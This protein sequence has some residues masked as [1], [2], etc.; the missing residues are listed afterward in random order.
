MSINADPDVAPSTGDGRTPLVLR[1]DRDGIIRLTMNLG[2]RFNPLSRPMI[3][4][5]QAHL[6]RIAADPGARVVVIA[7]SGRGFSAGHDLAEMSA[8]TQDRSWQQALFAECNTLMETLP[9]LPQPVIAQVHGIATA[10]GCQLAAM[11]DLVV[12]AQD[13]RF[14]LP[15]VNVGIFCSTPAVAVAR[16]IGRSRAMEMLLT[17]TPV[18]AATAER[19]G[20]VNRVAAAEDLAAAVDDLARIIT[21]HSAPVLAGGKRTFYAQIDQ[22][23]GQAY[24]TA[25]EQM[26][27]DLSGPDAAEGMAAFLAKR[28]PVWPSKA[29]APGAGD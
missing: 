26:V 3:A 9:A 1:E 22:G 20:L 6:D 28:V 23:L 19:W 21:A 12:A 16:R 15:G 11:C 13:S 24:R 4:A 27:C 29:G 2:S 25:A 18:D 17:G 10:A 14:A 5:L 7:G 8:H